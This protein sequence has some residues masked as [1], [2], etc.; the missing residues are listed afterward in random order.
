MRLN[1]RR[2]SAKRKHDNA[3]AEQDLEIEFCEEIL[4]GIFILALAM[5]PFIGI[6][7]LLTLLW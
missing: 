7:V 1:K 2:D 5:L 3:D 6:L 4:L